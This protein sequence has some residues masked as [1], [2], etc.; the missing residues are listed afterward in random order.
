MNPTY[1]WAC[2][3]CDTSNPPGT[4]TCSACQFPATATALEITNA[5]QR[6]DAGSNAA[7]IRLAAGIP[8][9]I[10]RIAVGVALFA[11]GGVLDVFGILLLISGLGAVFQG[12]LIGI[13]GAGLPALAIGLLL[14]LLGIL[15]VKMARGV[16]PDSTAP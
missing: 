11:V 9:K 12:T 15:L 14:L 10:G 7:A 13:H 4:G 5:K 16:F 6:L 8:F 2:H 3:S 1:S